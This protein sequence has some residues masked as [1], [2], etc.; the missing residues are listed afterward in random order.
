MV[1]LEYHQLNGEIE[2]LQGHLDQI[3]QRRKNIQLIND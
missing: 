2:G 1:E 3:T